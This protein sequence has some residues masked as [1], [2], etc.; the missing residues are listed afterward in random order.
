ME[1][2]TVASFVGVII[3]SALVGHAGIERGKAWVEVK[4]REI[5]CSWLEDKA[6]KVDKAVL[7]LQRFCWKNK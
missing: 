2:R 1:R 6:D 3:L 5:A 4:K 7:V